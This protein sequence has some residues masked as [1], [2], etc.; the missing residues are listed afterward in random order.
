[1]PLQFCLYKYKIKLNDGNSKLK[2]KSDISVAKNEKI[3]K[4]EVE[5]QEEIFL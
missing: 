1:M 5:E 3:F 4:M 2:K